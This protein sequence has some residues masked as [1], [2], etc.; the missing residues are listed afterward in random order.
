MVAVARG[1]YAHHARSMHK[2]ADF[3]DG[4]QSTGVQ[5]SSC[6]VFP[7]LLSNPDGDRP[8]ISEASRSAVHS[9]DPKRLLGFLGSGVKKLAMLDKLA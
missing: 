1:Q 8:E 4:E 5:Y 6:L 7:P 2:P 3:D 9:P